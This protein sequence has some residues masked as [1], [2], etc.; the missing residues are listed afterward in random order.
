MPDDMHKISRAA[1]RDVSIETRSRGGWLRVCRR[2]ASEAGGSLVE[3]AIVLPVLLLIVT[4]V[5]T[6]GIAL[7][8]YL[9]LTDAVGIGGRQLAIS[10][11]QTTDPCATAVSAIENAAPSLNPASYTSWT[12]VLNGTSYSGTSCSSSS[13]TTGAAGNLSQG[14]SAQV[15]VEYPCNLTVYGIN[16]APSCT[17]TA[18]ITELV[19]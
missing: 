8:N 7:N 12:F 11:G 13:T 2:A 6:F 16:Y 19:Q 10:R 3:F 14:K 18:Q 5:F 17:L 15:K 9:E 4:G 1:S